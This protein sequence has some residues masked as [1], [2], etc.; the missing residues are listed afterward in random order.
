MRLPKKA[1]EKRFFVMNN[2]STSDG[3]ADG[4]VKV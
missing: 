3:S 4:D 1:T 2:F